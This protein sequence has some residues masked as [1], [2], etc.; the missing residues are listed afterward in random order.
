MAID[1]Q[2]IVREDQLLEK[3]I[4]AREQ[5]LSEIA[6]KFGVNYVFYALTH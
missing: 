2:E 6:Y 5:I 4:A 3:L 1:T